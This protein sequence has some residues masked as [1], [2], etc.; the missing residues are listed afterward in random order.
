MRKLSWK[1]KAQIAWMVLFHKKTPVSAKAAIAG[2]VLYGFLPFDLIPDI[3]PLLGVADDATLI[4]LAISYFLNLTKD[5]RN[6]MAQ[7]PDI[8]DAEFTEK[9]S[10]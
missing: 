2:A 8:I 1:Q 5:I 7:K 4:I 6:E 3:I 10:S 9:R